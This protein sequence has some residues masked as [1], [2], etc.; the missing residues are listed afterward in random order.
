MIPKEVVEAADERISLGG[1][2]VK[3]G[4]YKG[5]EVFIC[6]F[7]EEMTIGLPELY[8][9]DGFSVEIV[10]GEKALEIMGAVS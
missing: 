4:E 6:E 10:G 5:S 9:W 2:P 7:R 1:K 8:L 3:I